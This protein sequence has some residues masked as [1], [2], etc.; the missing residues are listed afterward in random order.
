[1]RADEKICILSCHD[2][3]KWYAKGQQRLKNSLVHHGFNWDFLGLSAE[4]KTDNRNRPFWEIQNHRYYM[5]TQ[6]GERGESHGYTLKIAAFEHAMK[7]GYE[8]IMWLDSSVYAVQNPN[9]F[10]D[11]IGTT[12]YYFW[13]CGFSIGQTTSDRCLN[14]FGLTREAALQIPD[15]SSSMLGLH[16]GNPYA[17]A[18]YKDWKGAALA[19]VFAGSRGEIIPPKN[20]QKFYHRHDQSAASCSIWK[21]GLEITPVNTYSSYANDQGKYKDSV[22]FVMRG[23]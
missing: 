15:C 22:Y 3:T 18:F 16:M 23:M 4:A 9:P 1:M 5:P 21:N 10:F 6:T 2:N 13:P 19:G 11:V 12:G 7:L 8:I 17:Q 14:H 20:G